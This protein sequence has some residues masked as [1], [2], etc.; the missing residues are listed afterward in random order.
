MRSHIL[1]TGLAVVAFAA[2]VSAAPQAQTQG[3]AQGQAQ[4]KPEAKPDDKA[5]A[6]F[7]GKWIAT[8][9]TPNGAI[10][11]SLDIKVDGKKVAGT[12]ASQMGENKI[13]G[14][15]DNGTLTFWFSMDMGG[16]Q[17][18]ITFKGAAQKDGTLGGAVG[19]EGQGEMTW[20]ATRAK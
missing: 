15:I 3:Q 10:E 16:Q 18:S 12:I 5:G 13:E 19:I 14:E 20:T 7:A 17:V 1:V 6:T 11:T 2:S 9:Q 4:A 8:V